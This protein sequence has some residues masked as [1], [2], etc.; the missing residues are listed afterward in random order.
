[1]PAP[2]LD[3]WHKNGELLNLSEDLAWN[4]PEQKSGSLAIVGGNASSFSTEVKI[5]EFISK[6]YPFL[7]TVKNFFPDSLKKQFPPLENLEFFESSESGSFRPSFDFRNSLKKFDSCLLLGDLSKNSETAIAVADL[8]KN[9]PETNF[10]LTRDAVDLVASE[11]DSFIER[12]N[13][14]IIASLAQLQKLFRTLY[15]PKMLLLSSPLLPVVETLHKFT[16]SF[17]I[18]IL[19]FHEGEV[20]CASNGKIISVSLEKTDFSPISLWSGEVAARAAVFQL[21]NKNK[22]L[23]SL[24]AALK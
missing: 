9:S 2:S 6:K 12:E 19:T 17:P 3:Y 4:F 21:F 13:L 14:T 11:V 22:T 15:Y 7:K 16:L 1:M 8:I 10:L 5:S 20:L 24:V 18:S 23:D